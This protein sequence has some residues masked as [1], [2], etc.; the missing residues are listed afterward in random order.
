MSTILSYTIGLSDVC[1][2]HLVS[3]DIISFVIQ[4]PRELVRPYVAASHQPPQGWPT[5]PQVPSNGRDRQA[6]A[7]SIVDYSTSDLQCIVIDLIKLLDQEYAE[8]PTLVTEMLSHASD[9]QRTLLHLSALFGF[10]ELIGELISHRV[11]VNQR[12]KGGYTALH[13]AAIFGHIACVQ[14]LVNGDAHLGVTDRWGR[15][16]RELAMDSN[17]HGIEKILEGCR[18]EIPAGVNARISG[19]LPK[20]DSDHRGK[21]RVRQ[22]NDHVPFAAE[23]AQSPSLPGDRGAG[24]GAPVSGIGSGP[25]RLVVSFDIGTSHSAVTVCYQTQGRIKIMSARA[26]SVLSWHF[27]TRCGPDGYQRHRMAWPGKPIRS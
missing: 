17:H 8:D 1:C 10:H 16:A 19:G 20:V 26:M 12:D 21:P 22:S 15:L 25:P 9:S 24:G 6:E 4:G 3:A 23:D 2:R 13:Y 27:G 14:V 5:W 11:D 18:S 7:L